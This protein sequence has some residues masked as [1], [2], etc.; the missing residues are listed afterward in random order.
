MPMGKSIV[1]ACGDHCFNGTWNIVASGVIFGKSGMGIGD[2][3]I[4]GSTR[5]AVYKNWST[6][7]RS[8]GWHGSAL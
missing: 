8:D 7:R 6:P 5:G 3:E 4:Q 1:S 2:V